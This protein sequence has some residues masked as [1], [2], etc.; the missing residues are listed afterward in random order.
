MIRKICPVCDQLMKGQFF[1][2]HCHSF[3]TPKVMDVNY[4]LN[5]RHPQ[6]EFDCNY[7]TET[8]EERKQRHEIFEIEEKK[9]K[10]PRTVPNVPKPALPGTGWGSGRTAPSSRE[11]IPSEIPSERT[12]GGKGRPQAARAIIICVVIWIVCQFVAAFMA[13]FF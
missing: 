9:L 4:Y 13:F 8:P 11:G 5:E 10:K 2:E 3:V 6:G 12:A 1:C 7:H